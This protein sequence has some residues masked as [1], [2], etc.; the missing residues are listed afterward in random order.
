MRPSPAAPPHPRL[1][2]PGRG[3]GRRNGCP[4][5]RPAVRGDPRGREV[6]GGSS[7]CRAG[8]V[9][10]NCA[11]NA[12]SEQAGARS[13]SAALPCC[14][15]SLPAALPCCTALLHCPAACTLCLAA[16]FLQ[17]QVSF[18]PQRSAAVSVVG[19]VQSWVSGGPEA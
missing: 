5:S 17:V 14:L 4:P 12:R 3:R 2:D 9:L 15:P 7:R 8:C 1:R 11:E 13:R 16:A 19:L 6:T 18:N 10:C